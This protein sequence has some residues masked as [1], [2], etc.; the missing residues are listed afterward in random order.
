[1]SARSR[2]ERARKRTRRARK[3]EE[4]QRHIEAAKRAR[5][6]RLKRLGPLVEMYGDG[7]ELLV[8]ID[9]F[10]RLG[11]QRITAGQIWR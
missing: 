10:M 7:S 5:E 6:E 11:D 8:M 4:A 3:R 1:M 9:R 2:K